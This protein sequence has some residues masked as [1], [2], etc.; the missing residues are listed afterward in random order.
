MTTAV[1][2][3]LRMVWRGVVSEFIQDETR[4]EDLEGAFR[5]GK[6]TAALWKVFTS[7]LDFPGIA[8]LICRYTDGDTQT[9]LKPPWT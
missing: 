5:S 8:W 2:P 3:E 6:T 4:L 1:E 9:K 7:C